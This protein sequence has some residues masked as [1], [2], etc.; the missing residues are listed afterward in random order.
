[1]RRAA[2]AVAL[3]LAATGSATPSDFASTMPDGVADVSG[4][5]QVSG[6][7]DTPGFRGDYRFY[8]NPRLQALYQ[9]MRYH[10]ST[11]LAP[12]EPLGA[13][14][15]AFVRRPGTPEPM[16]CWERQPRGA[17]PQWRKLEPGS[18]EYVAE[19]QTLMRVIAMHRAA[20]L[21]P[22]H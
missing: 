15:V 20:A 12:G 2:F 19:M 8:V 10:T 7:F 3:L 5:E 22:G 9:V 1:M 18:S 17:V 11:S 14:R 4:W 21:G 13:E 16:A 6:D